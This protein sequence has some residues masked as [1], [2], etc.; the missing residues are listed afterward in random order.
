MSEKDKVW[1]FYGKTN[2]YFGVST[3]DKF[4][5]ENLTR[6]A[7]DE[8]FQTGEAHIVR[9]WGEIEGSFINDFKPKRALDFGCG[10]GRLVLPLSSR[11]AE[12]VGVD[13]SPQMLEE[14]GRNCA[15]R[16]ITNVD[17]ALS[18]EDL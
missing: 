7:K 1:E 9:I 2:P 16:G 14:T 17:L 13:I 8:F 4:K 15:E 10:V 6:S 18:D 12:V 3:I 5:D 11:C